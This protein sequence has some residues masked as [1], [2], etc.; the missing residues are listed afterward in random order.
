MHPAESNMIVE[1]ESEAQIH[2]SEAV[3][4]GFDTLD[5]VDIFGPGAAIPCRG[6]LNADLPEGITPCFDFEQQPALGHQA[7]TT[8]L[9]LY[10]L[11]SYHSQTPMEPPTI[12]EHVCL[13]FTRAVRIHEALEVDLLWINQKRCSDAVDML[14]NQK[15]NLVN[16]N[17][18]FE[19]ADIEPDV[20][21]TAKVIT[22]LNMLGHPIKPRRLIEVFEAAT[23]FHVYPGERDASFSANCNALAALLRQPDVLLYSSQIVKIVTFLCDRKWRADDETKDKW[24]QNTSHLY[25]SVPY[26]EALV[27]L[28][29]LVDQHKLPGVFDPPFLSKVAVTLFQTCLRPLP[30]QEANGSWNKSVDETAYAI[31]LLAEARRLCFFDN[32]R[33]PL[34]AAIERG[35]EFLA[36]SGSNPGSCIW[37]DK[38]SYGSLS[39]TEAYILAARKSVQSIR[40]ER[41]VGLSF[42]SESTPAR[43]DGRLTLFRQ[44]PLFKSLPEWELRASLLEAMLFQPLLEHIDLAIPPRQD[45]HGG[46]YSMI[47]PFTWT[48]CNNRTRT[49][50]SASL[51]YEMMVLSFRTYQI[52][53]FMEAVA[54]PAFKYHT[55]DLHHLVETVAAAV[56]N[57]SNG[58]EHCTDINGDHIKH[59]Q[60]QDYIDKLTRCVQ[61][62]L[63]NPAFQSASSNDRKTLEQELRIYL[64]AHAKQVADNSQFEIELKQSKRLTSATS[65]YFRWVY[66]TSA[67]HIAAP[68][69][70][71]FLSCMIGATLTPRT[72]TEDC[73]HNTTTKYFAAAACRNLAAM[74]R[75]YNDIGSWVR[76][77]EEGNLNSIH[78]PE[79]T[80]TDDGTKQAVL[81]D[82]AQYERKCLNH[83]LERLAVEMLN[84]PDAEASRLGKRR[85]HLVRMFCDVTD[86]SGQI[87]VLRDMSSLIRHT[88]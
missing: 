83:A 67:D 40:A 84:D 34:Q 2:D 23:H 3:L 29:A 32:L 46:T 21:N 87:Y 45:A 47:I 57:Y 48:S 18:L 76:D 30:D 53:E 74:C 63:E 82:L 75:M 25:S 71:A 15:R 52:D 50:A 70:F 33:H 86:L 85:M 9:D 43:M 5:C 6:D 65:I 44:T 4:L 51:L 66:S 22:T 69:C 61:S 37:S 20:D 80:G 81:F 42:W 56:P 62:I 7:Q 26:V 16:S 12:T 41:P 14:Q 73:F 59:S 55:E 19:S 1:A 72:T 36:S 78:F 79:F 8:D 28:L 38:V 24:I 11:M 60:Y 35:L 58:L 54:G 49:Y 31:L 13:C 27:D 77:H 68:M 39:I 88:M 64:L 17:V 10:D